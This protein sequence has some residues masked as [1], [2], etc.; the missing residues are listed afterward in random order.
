G[1]SL[2]ATQEHV[3]GYV[4]RRLVGAGRTC[5]GAGQVVE[6][7]ARTVNTSDTRVVRTATTDAAG[8][9]EF[10]VRPTSSTVLYGRTAGVRSL[11]AVVHVRTRISLT[12]TPSS[13]CALRAAGRTYPAKPGTTVHVT[14]GTATVDTRVAADGSYA[15]TVPVRCGT[16]P[17]LTSFVA[18]TYRN[19]EG[20]SNLP[21][22]AAARIVTCGTEVPG[23][24]PAQSG[25]TL[26]LELFNVT[27]E[28]D[29][30]WFG[31][32]VVANPTDGPVTY[33]PEDSFRIGE[34]YRLFRP[35][36]Y[37]VIGSE[38]FTDAGEPAKE[39]T[40]Q[41]GE[42]RR[43]RVEL[44]AANCAGDS[45]QPVYE[46]SF[47]PPLPAGT[48]VAAA[49]KRVDGGRQWSSPRVEVRVAD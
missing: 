4:L 38:R 31:E 36:S 37:A 49:V 29:G 20:R 40:L 28:V 11:D 8:R 7:L 1:V 23:P 34:P 44:R 18:R 16:R 46:S 42:E 13:A 32:V 47:G 33:R 45:G 2:T 15:A 30:S 19:D 10:T 12:T 39:M 43:V 41:P 14:G 25:L 17:A 35:A 48:Y 21:L 6:L 27:T 22:R 9:V 26:A 5:V 24:G 3:Q